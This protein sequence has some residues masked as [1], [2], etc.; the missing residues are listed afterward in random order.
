MFRTT[1]YMLTYRIPRDLLMP[2]AAEDVRVGALRRLQA[3]CR[4]DVMSV[5]RTSSLALWHGSKIARSEAQN[6]SKIIAEARAL[7][8][9]APCCD[10]EST[11]TF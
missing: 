11:C 4:R 1:V 9:K 2:E 3:G 8:Q 10:P 6:D 7:I 5:C